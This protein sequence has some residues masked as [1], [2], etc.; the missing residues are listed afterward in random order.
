[1]HLRCPLSRKSG[2]QEQKHTTFSFVNTSQQR[3]KRICL[4]FTFTKTV[5]DADR[6]EEEQ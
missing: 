6:K 2:S 3:S 5:E 1:M 4:R